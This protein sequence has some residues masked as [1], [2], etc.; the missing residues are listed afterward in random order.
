MTSNPNVKIFQ[1]CKTARS[2]FNVFRLHSPQDNCVSFLS[3][4]LY[5]PRALIPPSTFILYSTLFN[6]LEVPLNQVLSSH[7][8]KIRV[9]SGAAA[10]AFFYISLFL[11]PSRFLRAFFASAHLMDY[12][13]R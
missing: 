8:K 10:G 11:S 3:P 6:T 1:T 5:T 2:N 9:L 13:P 12:T 7:P 4:Q